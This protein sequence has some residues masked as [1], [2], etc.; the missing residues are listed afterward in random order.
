VVSEV[1]SEAHTYKLVE[2]DNITLYNAGAEVK[3]GDLQ[4]KK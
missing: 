1:N 4:L 3:E 2:A